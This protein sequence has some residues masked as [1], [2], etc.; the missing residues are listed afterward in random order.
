MLKSEGT[1][2]MPCE[3]STYVTSESKT[4]HF[5]RVLKLYYPLW[6]VNELLTCVSLSAP[7]NIPDNMLYVMM[8]GDKSSSSTKILL[9]V[10]SVKSESQ[11]STHF[12]NGIFEGDEDSWEC[13]EVIFG[14]LI[15]SVQEN[16]NRIKSLHL[17]CHENLN[18]THQSTENNSAHSSN[19]SNDCQS[20][21][22]FNV[23]G[24]QNLSSCLTQLDNTNVYISS[25]CK[26][27]V[28][29]FSLLQP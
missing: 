21:S 16:C 13:V 27:T 11:H 5:A 17:K 29:L 18:Y 14:H 8:A 1:L 28:S 15:R 2:E 23:N 25:N 20:T 24:S 26:H 9:Q 19:P 10:L 4:V 6:F 7:Q 3:T 12:T 22:S